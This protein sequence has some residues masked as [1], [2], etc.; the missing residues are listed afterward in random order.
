[1]IEK[2]YA[3]GVPMGGG[4]PAPA[5]SPRF[6]VSAAKDPGLPGKPGVD[7]Q[8]TQIVKGWLDADGNTHEKVFD[9]AGSPDN[10][11]GVDPRSCAPT[12]SGHQNLCTVWQDPE[13]DATQ[14]A[15]YYVRVLENPSCRWSTLQ[16]Q[17]AG[18]NP[19]APDC[20]EKAAA[21]T[22]ALQEQGAIGDVFGRCC[23]DPAEQPFYSP[24]IQERAWTS[25]IWID[26][27]QV[28]D[29]ETF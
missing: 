4:L 10:G 9:V 8:R 27:T 25:P 3:G 23:L 20:K 17:A 14:R 2:A 6:L 7:L 28:T 5:M 22:A 15:F 29:K 26:P 19:F 24:L 12:G 13:Y 11:A 1:M 21:R 16:C 18:V